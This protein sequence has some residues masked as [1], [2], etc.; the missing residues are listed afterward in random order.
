MQ[1][2]ERDEDLS[3][4]RLRLIERNIGGCLCQSVFPFACRFEMEAQAI[5]QLRIFFNILCLMRIKREDRMH[6]HLLGRDSIGMRRE[7][8]KENALVR[9]MLVDNVERLRALGNDIGE[10]NL[11][12]RQEAALDRPVRVLPDGRR[13][14]G[15]KSRSFLSALRTDRILRRPQIDALSRPLHRLMDSLRTHGRRGVG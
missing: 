6:E 12:D 14:R 11:A 1:I 10:V 7:T 13:Q 8:I 15:G 5:E 2:T 9:R 4:R 3:D